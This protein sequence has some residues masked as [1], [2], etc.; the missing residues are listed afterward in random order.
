M[1]ALSASGVP[2]RRTGASVDRLGTTTR[3]T[4]VACRPLTGTSDFR[5]LDFHH[6]HDDRRQERNRGRGD[7]LGSERADRMERERSGLDRHEKELGGDAEK[8]FTFS[9]E[10]VVGSGAFG[11]VYQAQNVQTGETVAIKK[12][13]QDSR[14]KNRELEM[15]Q[16]LRHP[17]IVEFKH[18]FYVNSNKSSEQYLNVVMEYCPDT[19][20]H[21]MKHYAKM[22][23]LVP[24]AFIQLYSY[25]ILRGLAHMHAMDIC[26][27]DIKPHNLLVDSRTH[28]LKVCDFGSAKRLVEGEPN[29]AY[30]CSR[31]YRAPE[32]ILGATD[33]TTVIDIWSAA[34]VTSE[35]LLGRVVFP[36]DSATDQLVEIIKVLG[37]PSREDLLSMNPNYGEFKFPPIKAHSWTK[38]FRRATPELVD[39]LSRILQYRPK[40]RPN[41]LNACAHIYFNELRVEGTQIGSKSLP[42]QLHWFSKEEY[43]LM[44]ETLKEMLIPDW[45]GRERGNWQTH[46]VKSA[47]PPACSTLYM[48]VGAVL[49]DAM[50]EMVQLEHVEHLAQQPA[51]GRA[52]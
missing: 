17:N 32:L 14:Y 4:E 19:V 31:F 43:A 29:T 44:D 23:Q 13:L 22:R 5:P 30:I 42:P 3:D 25:Q 38:V 2:T 50:V 49:Q 20:D 37:T 26:H 24:P 6:R 15:M 21:V 12:V 36:G 35:L 39:L 18:A 27:R 47:S 9:A 46:S 48:T 52:G 8:G 28:A 7:R 40:Q 51:Q 41:G 34:C 45:V 11:T 33:Y 16:E 1:A 10:R